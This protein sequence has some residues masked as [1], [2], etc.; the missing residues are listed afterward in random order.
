MTHLVQ[1]RNGSTRRVALVEEPHLRLLAAA[2]VYEL[3]EQAVERQTPL[4]RWVQ[5][6]TG[7]ERIDYDP[8][9]EGRS[10]W[11]LL[12]S[13]D[14]PIDPARCLVTGTGLTHLGSAK[15]R[16]AMHAAAASEMNDSMKMFTWGVEGGRPAPGCIGVAPEWFYKGTGSILRAPGEPLDVPPYAEDGGEE[17]EIAGI[18]FIA[19]DGTPLRIGMAIGNEFSDHKFEKR[20]YL[21]LAGSKLR[22]CALGPELAIDPEFESVPGIVKI[23]RGEPALVAGDRHGP[24]RDVPQPGQHRA[25]PFQVRRASP[26]WGPARA[27]FRRVQPELRRRCRIGGRRRH[28]H[29]LQRLWP[30]VAKPAPRRQRRNG[31]GA[32]PEYKRPAWPHV[33]WAM[34]GAKPPSLRD[35]HAAYRVG[36]RLHRTVIKNK[37]PYFPGA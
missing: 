3:V 32:R 36:A 11:Q 35:E 2:S 33:C 6:Q 30:P 37:E 12:P 23:Q 17:A 5:E 14:H 29:C 10:P 31:V 4:S 27:L 7:S 13:I 22:T 26:R 25:S 16:Q 8:V 34:T 1:I 21:N 15:N 28:A 19:A 24:A 20:N 9:Y 18:Y